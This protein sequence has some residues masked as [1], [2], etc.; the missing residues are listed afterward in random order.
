M[1]YSRT[2]K[3]PSM[4]SFF[5]YASGFNAPSMCMGQETWKNRK[6]VHFSNTISRGF[7]V[8]ASQD[9]AYYADQLSDEQDFRSHLNKILIPRLLYCKI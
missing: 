2:E 6:N 8:S 5:T 3:D 1:I 7:D 9:L 4:C